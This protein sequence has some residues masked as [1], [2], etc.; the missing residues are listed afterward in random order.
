MYSSRK[1]FQLGEEEVEAFAPREYA[2][3]MKYVERTELDLSVV[4][5]AFLQCSSDPIAMYPF[6]NKMNAGGA[7]ADDIY[8]ALVYKFNRLADAVYAKTNI[9]LDLTAP[10]GNSV[11]YGEDKTYWEI[12]NAYIQNEAIDEKYISVNTKFEFVEAD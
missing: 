7:E 6:S 9:L 12:S 2:L 1:G 4:A 5:D 3:F 11:V 8:A 10:Q